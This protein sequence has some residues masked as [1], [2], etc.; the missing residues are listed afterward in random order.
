M[1]LRG[2]RPTAA[3]VACGG[4][5]RDES[6]LDPPYIT[7]RRVTGDDQVGLAAMNRGSTH[8]TIVSP[9]EMK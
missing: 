6:R 1:P 8:R 5:R 9:I 3:R 4:P 2:M 7:F